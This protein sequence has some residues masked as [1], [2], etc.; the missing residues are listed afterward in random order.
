MPERAG[1][2]I[3]RLIVER[4]FSYTDLAGRIRHL[5]DAPTGP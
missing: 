3:G 1:G 5:L 4:E 2:E